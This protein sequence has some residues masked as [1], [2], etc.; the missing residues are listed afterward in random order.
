MPDRIT[1][2]ATQN[3]EPPTTFVLAVAYPT[4]HPLFL[5]GVR[6]AAREQLPAGFTLWAVCRG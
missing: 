1:V 3:G 2:T 4:W 5:L 6:D